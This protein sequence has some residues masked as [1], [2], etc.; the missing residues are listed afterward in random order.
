MSR[1]L[2]FKQI[3]IKSFRGIRDLTLNLDSKSLVVCGPNGTGKS[4]ITQAFEYL[5][6]G[7]V[8]ALT[9]I[10]GLNHDNAIIHKGDKKSD[11]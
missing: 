6:T 1:D 11:E 9:G 7:K 10:R 5:F 2:K 4:S 8:S 3:E